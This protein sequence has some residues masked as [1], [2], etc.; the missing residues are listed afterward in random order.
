MQL[1]LLVLVLLHLHQVQGLLAL[2]LHELLLARG[3]C[4]SVGV[5]VGGGWGAVG[6]SFRPFAGQ[7][8][9]RVTGAAAAGQR[10]GP[11][12]QL[13]LRRLNLRLRFAHAPRLL[14]LLL[15]ARLRH[16]LLLLAHALETGR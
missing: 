10:R 5:Q 2:H 14:A 8:G 11:A 7:A 12:G 16:C 9:R 13:T 3:L 6:V 15:E 1:L 4:W